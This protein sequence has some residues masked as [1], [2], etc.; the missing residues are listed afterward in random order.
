MCTVE[1]HH[2]SVLHFARI[3]ILHDQRKRIRSISED[4]LEKIQLLCIDLHRALPH[5]STLG[6]PLII[7]YNVGAERAILICMT[8]KVRIIKDEKN[9]K[10]DN[11]DH[12][13]PDIDCDLIHRIIRCP[14]HQGLW[15]SVHKD[16][17]HSDHPEKHYKY[18]K[19]LRPRN[20]IKRTVDPENGCRIRLIDSVDAED[21][22]KECRHGDHI[23]AKSC[24]CLKQP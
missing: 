13:D 17:Y 11:R 21:H 12:T 15:F 23:S 8:S 24:L 6:S 18:R 4:L 16:K 10:A 19:K 5:I 1:D 20:Q 14:V 3:I 7:E 9:R 22:R 2:T